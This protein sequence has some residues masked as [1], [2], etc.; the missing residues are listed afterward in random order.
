MF[1]LV[2]GKDENDEHTHSTTYVL[3]SL[4]PRVARGDCENDVLV[5]L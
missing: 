2:K 1:A 5:A 3:T 4:T